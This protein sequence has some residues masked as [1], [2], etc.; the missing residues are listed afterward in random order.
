MD[1]SELLEL[2]KKDRNAAIA[3]ER[4][5]RKNAKTCEKVGDYK[6]ALRWEQEYD[7]A[8]IIAGDLKRTITVIEN[9]LAHLEKGE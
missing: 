1:V 6:M 7:S 5:C 8:W 4:E 2:L 9:A 3:R